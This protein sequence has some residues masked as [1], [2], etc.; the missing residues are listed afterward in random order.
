MRY[1]LI[2]DGDSPH[3]LKWARALATVD[4]LELWAA[5]SRGF[6]AGF[7]DVLPETRRL[8]LHT[9][10]DAAGGLSTWRAVRR[11]TA[12]HAAARWACFWA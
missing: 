8:A 7:D 9:T 11:T 1:V 10:P 12:R 6:A 2:G 3:L 5:S 4:G